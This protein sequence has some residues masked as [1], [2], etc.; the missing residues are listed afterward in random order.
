MKINQLLTALFDFIH[1]SPLQ[2]PLGG[3]MSLEQISQKEVWGFKEG[4]VVPA[5][6]YNKIFV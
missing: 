6:C 4:F 2:P 3:P 1:F 5:W